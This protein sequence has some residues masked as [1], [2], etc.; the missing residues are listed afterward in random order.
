M[1]ISQKKIN[2]DKIKDNFS[3]ALEL[4]YI[5]MKKVNMFTSNNLS[6]L[7]LK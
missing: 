6:F 7:K 2:K 5:A 1:D 3:E 4:L